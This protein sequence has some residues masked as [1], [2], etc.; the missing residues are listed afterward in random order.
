MA[1]ERRGG[2]RP[3][4][5]EAGGVYPPPGWDDL[6]GE[7]SGGV[8]RGQPDFYHPDMAFQ[9]D[10]PDGWQTANSKQAVQAAS[11]EG[12]AVMALTLAEG[13]PLPRP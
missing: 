1:A 5:G 12:D 10:F 13:A 6:R 4:P 7:P 8:L 9:I 3:A 11:P 2:P